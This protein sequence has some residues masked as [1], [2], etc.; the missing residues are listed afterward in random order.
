MRKV[1]ATFPLLWPEVKT[2]QFRPLK[3]G[4]S[5]DVSAWITA[6]PQAGLSEEE[7]KQAVRFVASRLAYLNTLTTGNARV[8]LN[9]ESAGTVTAAE[10]QHARQKIAAIRA[11]FVKKTPQ[12][13]N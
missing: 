12:D 13:G 8:D 2:G 9:G 3:T 6:N 11:R 10:A 5:A 7:W 4:I 1:A